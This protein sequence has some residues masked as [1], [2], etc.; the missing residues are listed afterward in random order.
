MGQVVLCMARILPM[1]I[2]H[3]VYKKYRQNAENATA[4]GY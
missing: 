4:G 3:R 2:P 1:C